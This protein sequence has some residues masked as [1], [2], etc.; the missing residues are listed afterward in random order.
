MHRTNR[1]RFLLFFLLFSAPI[2]LVAQEQVPAGDQQVLSNDEI[3][4]LVDGIFKE[5]DGV[6]PL[7]K[8]AAAQAKEKLEAKLKKYKIS[9]VGFSLGADIACGYG[10]QH[11][12]FEAFFKNKKGHFKSQKFKGSF[13]SLGP[14][15][16]LSPI[17]C[18]V[19]FFTKSDFNYLQSTKEIKLG[20]GV[21]VVCCPLKASRAPLTLSLT[22]V[23]FL[24]AKG[25][26]LILGLGLG[27]GVGASIIYDGL[28]TPIVN[29]V[30]LDQIKSEKA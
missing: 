23:S 30:E 9:G 27:Y 21:D 3:S 25:G 20:W 17:K 6:A 18:N 10:K 4:V 13:K 16:D 5:T 22:Y 11:V 1:F 15:I 24:N 26:M 19:I 2:L 14:K 12:L 8:D 29:T 7:E 28:L